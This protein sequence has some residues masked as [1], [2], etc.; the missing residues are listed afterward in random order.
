MANELPKPEDLKNLAKGHWREFRPKMYQALQKSGELEKSLDLAVKNTVDAYQK[1]KQQLL[2]KGYEPNQAHQAA[3]EL[4]REEWL[5]LPDEEQENDL[6]PGN[7]SN[8][9]LDLMSNPKPPR[10]VE[11]SESPKKPKPR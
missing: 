10:S 2:E 11:I 4:V 7:L 1:V 8:Q 9:F 3:W 5:L 6:K